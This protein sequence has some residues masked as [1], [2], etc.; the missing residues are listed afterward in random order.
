[1][2]DININYK[3]S[4]IAELSG[5]GKK[6][7]KTSGKYCEGDIE[8]NYTPNSRSYEITLT[9]AS[10]WVLL[11][12][13]DADVLE[14]INDD[15]LVVSLSCI[16]AYAYEVYALTKV[17]VGNIPCGYD[18]EYPIYGLA[19]RTSN[20]TTTMKA[21]VYYKANNTGTSTSLSS[22][23]VFRIEGNKYYVKPGDG[24]IKTDTLRLTFTW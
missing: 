19:T 4:K 6:T 8:V 12:A 24:Y 15:S 2:A 9:K 14:H 10:G 23:G 18:G 22:L 16:D 17:I 21:G 13:L 5:T 1:M 7:L 3:G 20:E 11:S